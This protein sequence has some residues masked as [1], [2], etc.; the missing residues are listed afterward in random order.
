MTIQGCIHKTV[1]YLDEV[2]K[3]G[4][5]F[6]I[7]P[8]TP[9][10]Q[11][12][13]LIWTY[14]KRLSNNLDTLTRA[15]QLK[16]EDKTVINKHG[17]ATLP[18]IPKDKIENITVKSGD[19]A[20]NISI[21]ETNGKWLLQDCFDSY[22]VNESGKLDYYSLMFE[23][24]EKALDSTIRRCRGLEGLYFD[25]DDEKAKSFIKNMKN[26][27]EQLEKYIANEQQGKLF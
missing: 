13:E 1:E 20:I 17:W 23:S 16:I 11:M 2:Y 21:A 7:T 3:D 12:E 4:P 6:Y 5:H 22:F 15:Y 9:E 18:D 14:K 19:V 26:C 8:D 25:D 27:A 24:K 10:R